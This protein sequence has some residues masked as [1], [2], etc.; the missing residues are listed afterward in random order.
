VP[1][2]G[3]EA[4]RVEPVQEADADGVAGGGGRRIRGTWT[5]TC[6]RRPVRSPLHPVRPRLEVHEARR[7]PARAPPRGRPRA[8]RQGR[9]P[10]LREPALSGARGARGKD[11]LAVDV[12]GVGIWP[13]D[14]NSHERPRVL[15]ADRLRDQARRVVEVAED[16]AL[17]GAG[18]DAG[19]FRAM[20]MSRGCTSTTFTGSTW[21]APYGQLATQLPQPCG[22]P[23]TM[24][25][26]VF[27]S[28]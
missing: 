6:C 10:R 2:A 8:R 23:F 27:G 3:G 25:T 26:P 22:S 18:R 24:T 9:A 15:L 16:P 5:W 1:V 12:A 4:E 14:G 28:A 19:G 13:V 21:R 11:A 20:N 7:P 17:G